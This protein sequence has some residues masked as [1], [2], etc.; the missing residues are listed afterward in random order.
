FSP[1]GKQLLAGGRGSIAF[2]SAAPPIWN[3]PD[4]AAA[5]LRALLRSNA[6]FQSRIRMLSE[7]LRLHEAL[8]KLD[9]KDN[10]V[11]T[12]LAATQA[13][14]AGQRA[15]VAQGLPGGCQGV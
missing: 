13:R 14:H 7:N 1:D 5:K 3:D 6:D 12:A 11:R 9:A 4:L 8:A 2:W 15:C 10:R